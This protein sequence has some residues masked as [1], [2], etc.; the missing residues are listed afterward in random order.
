MPYNANELKTLIKCKILTDDGKPREVALNMKPRDT[1]NPLGKGPVMDEGAV[2]KLISADKT[3]DQRWLPWIF[4]E[5]AGGTDGEEESEKRLD[6]L[7]T[8]FIDSRTKGFVDKKTGTMHPPI[9]KKAA[10]ERWEKVSPR[11]WYLLYYGDQDMKTKYPRSLAYERYWPGLDRIYEKVYAAVT[12]FSA[13]ATKLPNALSRLNPSAEASRG[14]G[15]EKFLA[16]CKSLNF[17][18]VNPE[19]FKSLRE[20][21]LFNTSAERFISA[22][23]ARRDV[24]IADD[25][26]VYDDANITAL[27]PLTGAASVRFGYEQWPGADPAYFENS[28]FTSGTDPY[29]DKVVIFKFK[30]PVPARVIKRSG[31]WE[32]IDIT[33]L[34]FDLRRHV[35]MSTDNWDLSDRENGTSFT[36]PE[37]RNMILNEPTR[38]EDTENLPIKRGANVYADEA[39]AKRVADSFDRAVKAVD[40]WRQKYNSYNLP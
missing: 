7:R 3:P 4:Y 11:Y 17:A 31:R 16:K 12:S 1:P 6:N 32:V 25:K 30:A 36:V 26:P 38:G 24:R 19:S 33:D 34:R 23:A 20:L 9:S 15:L 18:D 22:D 5:A 2:A 27:V 39:E 14:E 29:K 10:E 21:E 37:I 35:G 8:V 28:L 13:I 40:V